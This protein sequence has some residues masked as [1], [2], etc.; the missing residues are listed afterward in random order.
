MLSRVAMMGQVRIIGILREHEA[1]QRQSKCVGANGISEAN[2]YNWKTKYSGMEVS[3]VNR[4]TRKQ[5]GH[6]AADMPGYGK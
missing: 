2:F 5:S 1:G 3:D 4:P 6:R